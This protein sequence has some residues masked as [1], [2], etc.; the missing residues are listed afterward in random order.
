[1]PTLS[2]DPTRAG[3]W[4]AIRWSIRAAGPEERYELLRRFG[5]EIRVLASPAVRESTVNW[6]FNAAAEL[7]TAQGALLGGWWQADPANPLWP[8]RDRVFVGR[9]ED[10][11]GTCCCLAALGF[12]P[13]TEVA[14]RI[15]F[16]LAAGREG[17]I[18]GLEV[19]GLPPE[20][21]LPLAWESAVESGRSKRRWREYL[22]LDSVREWTDAAWR[23]SPAVWR[24]F[25][26]ADAVLAD[27][28]L[29]DRPR[30]EQD[31]PAGLVVLVVVQ[32]NDA[33]DLAREW[34]NAGWETTVVNRT[35]CLGLYEALATGRDARPTAVML[36]IGHAPSSP[37]AR[38]ARQP[39]EVRLLGELSDDQFNAIMDE[40]LRF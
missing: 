35:D 27:R 13:E 31:S 36:A 2:H 8:G 19:P 11:L 40:S 20:E 4:R 6:D 5:N 33:P 39:R 34:H 10:L 9:R 17:V 16:A 22:G 38:I 25:V 24:T 12:F 21:V 1:M 7:F 14:T 15:D 30:R 23:D 32:R 37:T 3:R 28:E 18:P 29:R 26:V